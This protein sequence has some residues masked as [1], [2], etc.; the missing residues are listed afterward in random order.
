MFCVY[1]SLLPGTG[2]VWIKKQAIPA[3]IGAGCTSPP[4]NGPCPV[5][6][7][8]PEPNSGNNAMF[9]QTRSSFDATNGPVNEGSTMIP[10]DYFKGPWD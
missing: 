1:K 3:E 2:L 9:D 5:P 4:P 6:A 8:D 10:D 7:M